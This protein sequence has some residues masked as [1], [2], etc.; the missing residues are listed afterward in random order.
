M[1]FL[2]L[3]DGII[4]FFFKESRVMSGFN[5]SSRMMTD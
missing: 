1:V 3:N 5:L 2:F 4:D